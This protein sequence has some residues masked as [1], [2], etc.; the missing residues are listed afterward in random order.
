MFQSFTRLSSR[1]GVSVEGSTEEE[2]ASKL[3]Y[4]A[5]DRAQFLIAVGRRTSASYGYGSEATLTT[6][7]SPI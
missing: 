6:W 7:F 3:T 1:S 2:T 4:V 5:F